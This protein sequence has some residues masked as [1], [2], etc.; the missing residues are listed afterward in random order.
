MS[1]RPV[2]WAELRERFGVEHAPGVCWGAH[3]AHARRAV[4]HTVVRAP[5]GRVAWRDRGR[6]ARRVLGDAYAQLEEQARA[7][8]SSAL[9]SPA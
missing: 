8:A 6:D 1:F 3:E 9:T 5:S 2:S 7:P 4:R